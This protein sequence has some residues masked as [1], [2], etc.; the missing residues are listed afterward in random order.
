MIDINSTYKSFDVKQQR[1]TFFY[2]NHIISKFLKRSFDWF[3][4]I[5]NDK[6]DSIMTKI[7]N[8]S[9]NKSKEHIES[10][11]II[12]TNYLSKYTD[13]FKKNATFIDCGC[14]PGGFLSFAANNQMKGYGITLQQ[15]KNNKGL[16]LKYNADVIYGDLLDESFLESLDNKIKEKVDFVNM[17]AVLYDKDNNLSDQTRLFLNQ[18]YVAKKFLKPHGSIMFVL[19]IF[20][21]IFNLLT[22]AI[23]FIERKC[24]IYFIPVQ[25]TF[26]TTQ[27]YVLIENINFTD[28]MFQKFVLI[29]QQGFVPIVSTFGH[30][31]EKLFTSQYFN[32]DSFEEAYLINLLSKKNAI[33]NGNTITYKLLPTMM[34]DIL[35]KS[36]YN[37][38]YISYKDIITEI[39]NSDIYKNI[40]SV[41]EIINKISKKRDKFIFDNNLPIDQLGD[42]NVKE[43]KI[44]PEFLKKV[45]KFAK[46]IA[47]LMWI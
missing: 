27:V 24:N 19:D 21:T 44:T 36:N 32:I 45:N 3:T 30:L 5:T 37:F 13:I 46:R 7:Q 2:Y 17:G 29:K 12:Y 16:E 14:A 20:Y 39:K 47:D 18:F 23:F 40:G 31:A 34:L 35:T 6:Y 10:Y 22:I 11:N 42:I 8:I 25:P 33:K 4:R 38:R 15:T 41:Y 43:V 26:Q 9:S 1:N 28:E